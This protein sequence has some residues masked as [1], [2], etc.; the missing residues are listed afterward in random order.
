MLAAR[1]S[2]ALGAKLSGAGG[3]GVMI[4]LVESDLVQSVTRALEEV[5][6]A[7]V[8]ATSIIPAP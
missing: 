2:G 5:G 3:G 6:A 7:R 4:A 8:L 1:R